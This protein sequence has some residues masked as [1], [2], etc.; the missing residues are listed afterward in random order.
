MVMEEFSFPMQ[1]IIAD[2]KA[3]IFGRGYMKK[4]AILVFSYEA[5]QLN[6]NEINAFGRDLLAFCDGKASI[7]AIAEKL[8]PLYGKKMN[9][10]EFLASCNQA[11][12]ILTQMKLLRKEQLSAVPE[13]KP[14]A[15]ALSGELEK[16]SEKTAC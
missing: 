8:Y 9:S 12:E 14:E 5:N 1:E 11:V 6:I 10:S 4:P 2:L 3:G 13:D 15:I 16:E 7:P